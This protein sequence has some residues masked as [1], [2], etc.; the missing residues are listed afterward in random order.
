MQVIKKSES[1]MRT[2]FDQYKPGTH[3]LM[4]HLDHLRK[5]R[6][7]QIVAP[8]HVSVWPTIKCQMR[9]NVCCC[10]DEDHG[11]ETS[12][13]WDDYVEAVRV[14]SVYGTKAIELSGGGEPLLWRDFD[15]GVELAKENGI[16]VGLVTNGLELNKTPLYVLEKFSWIRVSVYSMEQIRDIDFKRIPATVSLS[17][18]LG[19]MDDLKNLHEFAVQNN[20]P[21]RLA[22]MQPSI[23]EDDICA[24]IAIKHYG[25]PFFFARKERG[26]PA[27]CYMPW[28]RAAIDWTGHFLPCP[29]VML[30]PG[31]VG[32]IADCFRLCHVR[33]LERWL[34]NNSPHD[35]GF[36]CG[37]CNCGKEHNDFIHELFSEV[38]NVEF[39]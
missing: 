12:I 33:D 28:I 31:S 17:Y 9:C 18:I 19:H 15:K 14:L 8:L 36:R 5:I 37:F 22:V 6:D 39:V 4:R 26:I 21:V 2:S 20:L 3:K 24:E 30:V 38:G 29:S 25:E 11:A 16:A 1:I 27:G 34:Q 23:P 35:M 13:P 7:G 32:K 10:Q